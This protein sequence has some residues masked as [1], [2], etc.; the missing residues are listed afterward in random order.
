M[1]H[2][3]E[4][5]ILETE[6]NNYDSAFPDMVKRIKFA[7]VAYD[8]ESKGDETTFVMKDVHLSN[9]KDDNFIPF[10]ELKHSD[11]V[12]FIV[13]EL[14]EDDIE[15]MKN[16]MITELEERKVKKTLKS[17]I[18]SPWAVEE[19]AINE[20]VPKFDNQLE[21]LLNQTLQR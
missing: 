11:F 13:A 5:D 3:F 19:I 15:F 8:V 17:Q 10:T 1:A 20:N 18:K 6:V 2:I 9:P 16:S 21:Y 7:F 12:R 14:G 4:F